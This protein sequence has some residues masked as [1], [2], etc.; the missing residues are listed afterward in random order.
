M[1]FNDLACSSVLARKSPEMYA[2]DFNVMIVGRT[3]RMGLRP[4]VL[5][6]LKSKYTTG[7]YGRRDYEW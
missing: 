6:H 1:Q 5:S 4:Q 7:V 3:G 2:Y